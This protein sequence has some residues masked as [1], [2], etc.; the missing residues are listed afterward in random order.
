MAVIERTCIGCRTRRRRDD[1]IRLQVVGNVVVPGGAHTSGR[2]AYLCPS[3]ACWDA[4]LRHKAFARA[5]RMPVKVDPTLWERLQGDHVSAPR[6]VSGTGRAAI[7]G[8]RAGRD[9]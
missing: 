6:L 9:E 7:D 5:F 1:L 4:A 2:S 3:R 8:S